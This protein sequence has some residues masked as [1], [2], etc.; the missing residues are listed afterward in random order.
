MP[1][2]ALRAPRRPVVIVVALLVALVAAGGCGGGR[3]PV[4]RAGDDEGLTPPSA[5]AGQTIR[6]A[7]DLE[8]D[9]ELP[10]EVD[11][12][13][14]PP[15]VAL[16]H[17]GQYTN[18]DRNEAHVVAV[19]EAFRQRGFATVRLDYH[20]GTEI[21]GQLAAFE[22]R[23]GQ[24]YTCDPTLPATGG[25]PADDPGGPGRPCLVYLRVI[26][27]VRSE[28]EDA[29]RVIRERADELGVDGDRLDLYGESAG[30][31]VALDIGLTSA[32]DLGLG[33]VVGAASAVQ[34][35]PDSRPLVPMLLV[36]YEQDPP[37]QA[38]A[39][40]AEVPQAERMRRAAATLAERG[41]ATLLELPG[42]GHLPDPEV[43]AR[44]FD[45]VVDASVAVFL[46]AA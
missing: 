32:A 45:R 8:G 31:T 15:V 16:V 4:R 43:D 41:D 24:E 20:L 2:A 26:A 11:G 39:H 14:P 12:D 30:A 17:G 27:R 25:E 38:A 3:R 40:A 18:G 37:D 21:P 6:Y 42:V 10:P 28:V 44:D 34:V 35:G 1:T 5:P 29:L 9:V 33:G 7:G 46:H 19:A 13:E 22:E 23:T 36:T